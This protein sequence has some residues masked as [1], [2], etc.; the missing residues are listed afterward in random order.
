MTSLTGPAAAG[1]AGTE[2]GVKARLDQ[3]NAQG[4]IGGRQLS[5]VME[6]DTT[7]PTGAATAV[8]K[9]IQQDNVF[10]LLDV[11]AFFFGGYQAATQAKLPVVGVSYDGGPE[12]LAHTQNPT[13]F[14]FNGGADYTKAATT[15]GLALKVMGVTKLATI[16]GVTNPSQQEGAVAAQDSAAQAG[17]AKGYFTRLAI[18]STDVG[19]FVIGV[20]STQSDGA[21]FPTQPNT[22]F[23]AIAGLGQ[24]GV[25]MKGIYLATGYGGDLLA[26][27]PA[28]AA[29]QG[30]Y[31]QSIAQ[32]VEMHTAA[33]QNLQAALK[34]YAGYTGV[35]TFSMYQGWLAADAFIWG[36]QHA[37]KNATQAD[38]VKYMN[39]G[40]G[41]NA[42]GLFPRPVIFSTPGTVGASVG[43]GNC[44]YLPQLKGSGFV[45]NPA[46]NPVCG[47]LIPGVTISP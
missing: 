24:A 33:T 41:W 25:K 21:Y 8:K 1:F 46:L 16:G 18:G 36:M 47:A 40:A 7:S 29:G 43:P 22:A 28:V 19:P 3:Q 5:Y 37:G 9:A 23:A 10:G 35:P 15:V 44:V 30:A 17:I 32:P 39:S 45:I 26:S 14:D 4:G 13:L 38:F 42:G 20:K 11:S 27:K 34:T 6:D 2:T 12:W 31:F